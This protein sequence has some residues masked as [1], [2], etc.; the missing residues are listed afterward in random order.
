MA[1]P[2]DVVTRTVT[3]T[4]LT[5]QGNAAVGRVTF[6]PTTSVHDTNDALVVEDTITAVLNAN[7][8]FSLALPTTDNPLLSP[9][10]WAYEVNVR[11]YGVKPK[12]FNVTLPAGDGTPVSIINNL[13][14]AQVTPVINEVVP[15]PL[16][17]HIGAPGGTFNDV[18]T[19]TV[20]GTYLSA[21]GSP[22][23]G[24]VTF[25]PTTRVVDANDA[26][27][28][29]GTLTAPLDA[30]GSFE[31]DLPTTDNP[32]LAPTGWAY[33]VSVRIHGVKPQKFY[34]TL[35]YGNGTP[36]DIDGEISLNNSSLV[37]NGTT[38]GQSVQGPIGPRGPGTI[39]GAGLPTYVVGQDGDI[40][41][42]TD[43]GYYYGPKTAG[44]W[45]GVPLYIAD[46]TRR[47]VH[48]QASASATWTITHVLGGRP[49][50][51]VVDSSGTVVVGEVRYDS[52]TVVTV[53]FTTSFSGYA[54]LT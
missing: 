26:V 32:L 44:E 41:I 37:S 31:I 46:T 3:G 8:A 42:D 20:I 52:N 9:S 21:L 24:R 28:V 15:T 33:E 4:Y 13:S 27:I 11:L 1:W 43:T 40:Y 50:V 10:G 49:S 6:T 12:K 23:N 14:A 36:V 22:A 18:V 35:P 48:T 34:I 5:P 25:T 54:Y 51:S 53:L 30:T 29:E 17:D 19:R 2:N 7:G 39:V 16:R 38:S 45:P 47:H